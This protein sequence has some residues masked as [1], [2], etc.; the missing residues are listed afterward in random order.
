MGRAALVKSVRFSYAEKLCGL[1]R[2][3]PQKEHEALHDLSA[4]PMVSIG[5]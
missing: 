1:P 5:G 3:R 2:S 4:W